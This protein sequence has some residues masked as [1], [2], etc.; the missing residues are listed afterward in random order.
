MIREHLLLARVE[1]HARGANLGVIALCGLALKEAEPRL[2]HGVA[3]CGEHDVALAR[4]ALVAALGP[5]GLRRRTGDRHASHHL[6]GPS[7]DDVAAVAAAL[8][9]SVDL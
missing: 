1:R 9:G 4:L 8:R 7:V 5:V 6:G 3:G 2:V